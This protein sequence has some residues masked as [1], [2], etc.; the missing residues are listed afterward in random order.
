MADNPG[1]LLQKANRQLNAENAQL[2]QAD[3][4][5]AADPAVVLIDGLEQL[6]VAAEQ[7]NAAAQ[8]Y[9]GL[10]VDRIDRAR[11]HRNGIAI[12]RNNGHPVARG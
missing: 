6:I 12:V 5:R 2:K 9:V 11:A 3:A 8:M 10:L 7:G 1:E 4:Q